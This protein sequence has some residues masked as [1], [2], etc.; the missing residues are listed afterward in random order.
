ML[1]AVLGLA[2]QP[3]GQA[4]H[5]NLTI[6][7]SSLTYSPVPFNAITLRIQRFVECLRPAMLCY[8]RV[9]STRGGVCQKPSRQ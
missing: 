8:L 9:T 7:P 2:A 3:V 4:S 1:L 5:I 6:C